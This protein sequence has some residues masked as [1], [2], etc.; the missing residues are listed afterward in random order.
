MK[1]EELAYWINERCE[2]FLKRRRGMP[3]PWTK[4]PIMAG[5]RWCN[6]HREDDSVTV[7]MHKNWRYAEMPMWW[8]VL[9]RMLNYIPS[10]E[11]IVHFKGGAFRR[12]D[13][14]EILKSREAEGSKLWTSAYT[15]STC[16]KKMGKVDYVLDWVVQAFVKMGEPQYL[17]LEETYAEITCIDGFGSFLA[18]QVIADC[19]NTPGHPLQA[20]ADW[21][22]WCAPGPGS[23]RGLNA[24]YDG[25][26][27]V[28][29]GNFEYAIEQCWWETHTLLRREV[30]PMHRQDFQNCL[31]EFS[32]YMRVKEGD[33]RVRN[34]YAAG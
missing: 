34:K 21:F 25:A 12:E 15:I 14:R 1:H 19:K 23:L 18:G 28:T 30:L 6:V 31:C 13:M 27:K 24:Y 17:S 10:L 4:D 9:G 3:P 7:W 32:K 16:G 8:I 2:M 26:L 20:T 5:V 29:T 11:E 22:T 33:G